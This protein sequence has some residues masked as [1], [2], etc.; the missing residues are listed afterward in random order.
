VPLG[1]GYRSAA[2]GALLAVEVLAVESI[3]E[4]LRTFRDTERAMDTIL[5]PLLDGRAVF[6]RDLA[7]AIED[8]FHALTQ[9]KQAYDT[10]LNDRGFTPAYGCDRPLAS[11]A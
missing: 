6:T 11:S 9:A 4:R 5:A 10:A 3:R 2:A 1:R 8:G 7:A